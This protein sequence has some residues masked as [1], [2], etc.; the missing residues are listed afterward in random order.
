MLIIS[1]LVVAFFSGCSS[2]EIRVEE[3][4]QIEEMDLLS[5]VS[6]QVPGWQEK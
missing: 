3:A 2:E 5:L 1:L 6:V 4:P